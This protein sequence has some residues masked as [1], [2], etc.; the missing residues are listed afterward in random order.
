MASYT[1]PGFSIP[2]IGRPP[3]RRQP[4]FVVPDP[5]TYTPP[6]DITAN[7]YTGPGLP[8]PSLGPPPGSSGNPALDAYK[9]LLD[10]QSV[11]DRESRNAAIRRALIMFGQIPDNFGYTGLSQSDLGQIIDPTTKELAA[12]NTESKL[13][14][15]ARL[16]DWNSQQQRS[17]KNQ[18]AA[19]GVY[20][21]GETGYQLGQQQTRYTQNEYDAYQQLV[22]YLAGAQTA[23]VQ[24]ENARQRALLEYASGLQPG[25]DP[26]AGLTA[27]STGATYPGAGTDWSQVL[28]SGNYSYPEINM[29]GGPGEYPFDLFGTGKGSPPRPPKRK[30]SSGGYAWKAQ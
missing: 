18:L 19:K 3:K 21:S 4:A 11:A 20:R 7:P 6:G 22:D 28:G 27:P 26:N 16:L 12:K 1:P 9:A 25:E 10:A 17:I 23:F 30:G 2:G 5:Y 15:V 8:D 14:T 24:A 13:S 29:P